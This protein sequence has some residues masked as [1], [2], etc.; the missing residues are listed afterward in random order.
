MAGC[1]ACWNFTLNN[2]LRPEK[3]NGVIAHLLVGGCSFPSSWCLALRLAGI[4][5]RMLALS[6]GTG[7]GPLARTVGS[8]RGWKP[9]CLPEYI[10]FS[11]FLMVVVEVHLA[12]I[13]RTTILAPKGKMPVG[14]YCSEIDYISLK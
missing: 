9:R 11:K 4:D 10:V 2:L 8:I 13:I 3:E 14:T 5:T 1:H 7:V 6:S 12:I